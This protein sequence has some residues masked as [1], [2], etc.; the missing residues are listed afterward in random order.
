VPGRLRLLVALAAFAALGNSAIDL[1]AQ[2]K[3]LF[4]AQAEPIGAG[5]T[6]VRR[7]ASE[8]AVSLEDELPGLLSTLRVARDGRLFERSFHFGLNAQVLWA[9]DAARLAITGSESGA[10]GQFRTA[11]V[12]LSDDTIGWLDLTPSIERTF[13]HPVKCGHDET[14]NV[15]AVTW[16]SNRRLVVAAEII[17]HSNCDS[18][19]TFSA[20]DVDVVTGHVEHA[21]DQLEAKRRWHAAL[22]PELLAAPDQC[23]RTPPACFVATNHPELHKD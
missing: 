19:G 15:V 22:G 23:I 18:F 2:S 9:P 16:R 6:S 21:Y 3:A 11:V 5:E 17:N 7:G 12:T 8:A 4:A 14:P 13:G 20:F 10:N 1:L